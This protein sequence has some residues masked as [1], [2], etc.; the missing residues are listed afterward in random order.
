MPFGTREN[1]FSPP[2][3]IV[4]SLLKE[5]AVANTQRWMLCTVA[6]LCLVAGNGMAAES[7]YVGVEIASE[8]LS[9]GPDISFV[10]GRPDR[11]FD[12]QAYGSSVGVLAGYRW[13]AGPDFSIALQGRLS[14]GDTA[15]KQELP[16]P[17]SFK[18]AVPVNAAVSLLPTFHASENL[19]L[20]AEVGLAMGKIQERKSAVVTSQY[21]VEKWQPGGVAGA[22]MS[23]AVADQWSV[24]IG[25]RRTW[26]Q[27]LRYNTYLADGTQVETN[28]SKPVQSMWNLGLIREF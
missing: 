21:D 16:E 13:K 5:E 27:E 18:Y 1:V 11:S 17:A 23:V 26:Y 8:H 10:N 9:F 22:G 3:C 28:S 20:F 6:A 14:T 7:Y 19:A 15:W 12:D 25:Y 2:R 4:T 24:R